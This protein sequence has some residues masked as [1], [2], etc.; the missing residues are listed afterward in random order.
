MNKQEILNDMRSIELTYVVD[1]PSDFNQ[2]GGQ[3]LAFC[4]IV[5]QNNF[6]NLELHETGD[7]DEVVLTS[8]DLRNLADKLRQWADLSD[9]T[10]AYGK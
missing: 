10:C 3:L 9:E 1:E 2:D 7:K 5:A 4:N 6:V 8:N